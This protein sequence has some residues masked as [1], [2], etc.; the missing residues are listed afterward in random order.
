MCPTDHRAIGKLHDR[1]MIYVYN[2]A[3]AVTVFLVIPNVVGV[4]LTD[5]GGS[6]TLADNSELPMAIAR[7]PRNGQVRGI[8]TDL[9]PAIHAAADAV[10][11]RHGE[12]ALGRAVQP[13]DFG[14]SHARGGGSEWQARDSPFPVL[15]GLGTSSRPRASVCDLYTDQEKT[16]SAVCNEFRRVNRIQDGFFLGFHDQRWSGAARCN[17]DSGGGAVSGQAD[18]TEWH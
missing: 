8:L 10:G 2:V 18:N 4:T 14:C 9:S 6:S 15:R 16:V 12:L 5:P 13:R 1:T 17:R 7:N 3:L 11:E